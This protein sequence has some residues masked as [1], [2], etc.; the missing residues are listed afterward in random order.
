MLIVVCSRI[1]ELVNVIYE[2]SDD[3][4]APSCKLRGQLEPISRPY[5]SK[6][7]L[8]CLENNVGRQVHPSEVLYTL[9]FVPFGKWLITSV[10][11]VG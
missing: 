11:A 3:W 7:L 5:G 2:P 4:Q 1:L 8:E 10:G 6:Y 9:S